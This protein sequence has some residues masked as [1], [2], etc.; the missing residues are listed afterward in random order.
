ML[1]N[2]YEVMRE[3]GR[4]GMGVVYQAMDITLNRVV[5]VKLLLDANM[6]EINIKRFVRE[7]EINA[8]MSHPNIVYVYGFGTTPQCYLVMEFIEGRSFNTLLK[9]KSYSLR[10]KLEVFRQV[11]EAVEYAHQHKII[12]RD[13]K[14]QN[15]MVV[16]G[17][18]AKVMDF[19]LA[20]SFGIQSLRLSKTGQTLGTPQYMSPEQADGSKLDH[21]TDIYSLGAILYEILTG[22]TPFESDNLI[23]I[24]QQ[25]ANDEPRLPRELNPA[26]SPKLQAICMK[27]L[28]KK[29]EDR[30][31]SVQILGNDIQAYLENRPV[32]VKGK[33]KIKR[34]SRWM[35]KNKTWVG[36]LIFWALAA[37]FLLFFYRS[38]KE[39][40]HNNDPQVTSGPQVAS[41]P[42]VT[43]GPQTTINSSPYNLPLEVW[44]T[45]KYEYQGAIMLDMT[46][47]YWCRLSALKQ[48]EYAGIYQKGY[49]AA[50]KL[51]VEKIVPLSHLPPL[52]KPLVMRLIPPGRFWMGS[53][54]NEQG[55]NILLQFLGKQ[56][57]LSQEDV[58]R[59]LA[60]QYGSNLSEGPRH[61]VVISSPYYLSKYECTQAQWQAVMGDNP[62]HF[63]HVGP[64]GPVECVS[65][66]SVAHGRHSFCGR[67]GLAL[68]CEAHWEYACRAGTTTMSHGGDF[69][70][71]GDNNAP[72]LSPVAWYGGNSG[73]NYEGSEDSSGWGAKEQSHVRA[74]THPVGQ[75]L[76]NG[77]GLHDTLGNVWE[78][79]SDNPRQYS[80]NEM[81]NVFGGNDLSKSFVLRSGSWRCNAG[82]CRAAFRDRGTADFSNYYLGFRVFTI[83]EK[84]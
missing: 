55:H 6:T 33:T 19:G 61:R 53:P 51:D 67:T 41:V 2:R 66:D 79:C 37:S 30:Y 84:K 74:G 46:T 16:E 31:K 36:M 71:I 13:L 40:I 24:F 11:C 7:A 43:S 10:K 59:A 52:A 83:D 8:K 15:I 23:N 60:I 17:N 45:C 26:I 73:V 28:E 20:K 14:P 72:R 44:N 9:D 22:H 54:E 42:Q 47:D 3:L 1:L 57:Q 12:H 78:W 76:P 70:I 56:S 50:K 80:H 64:D 4:G 25:L 65:L 27:C 68:P 38:R 81:Y 5:A 58:K 29:T 39:S 77:F 18:V 62:S 35:K 48:S 75:K 49:A 32:E 82:Y 34:T 63:Q 69:E 21:H